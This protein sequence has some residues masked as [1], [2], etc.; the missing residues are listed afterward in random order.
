M[1]IFI[2]A[3]DIDIFKV[4]VLSPK[5]PKN[6]DGTPKEYKDFNDENWKS[7]ST[8]SKATLLL[9]CAMNREKRNKIS[10]CKSAME[11]WKMLKSYS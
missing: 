6:G 5:I 11:I 10:S 1:A 9:Y 7:F 2:Q 3:Y 8:Y 4:I